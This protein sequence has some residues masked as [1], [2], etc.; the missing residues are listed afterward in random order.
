M[1]TALALMS[2]PSIPAVVAS[3]ILHNPPVYECLKER[4]INYHA[5]AANIK[6]EVVRMAGKP[7]TINREATPG[8]AD[9]RSQL[10]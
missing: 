10:A 2:K 3:I 1:A 6:A 4:L 8:F 7:T 9:G 5:L